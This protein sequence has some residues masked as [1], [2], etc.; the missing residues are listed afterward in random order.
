MMGLL[1]LYCSY[2]GKAGEEEKRS[3]MISSSI[4][5]QYS[6]I[7]A[8]PGPDPLARWRAGL[9]CYALFLRL[10]FPKYHRSN[11]MFRASRA[12][13]GHHPILLAETDLGQKT[14]DFNKL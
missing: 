4:T 3:K 2:S 7:P 8:F 1:A 10:P 14:P 5:D 12:R 13:A 9:I 6:I 11:S